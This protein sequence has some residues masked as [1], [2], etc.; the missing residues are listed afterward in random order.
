MYEIVESL[1][2]NNNK[3][4]EIVVNQPQALT[5]LCWDIL[6]VGTGVVSE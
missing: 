6:K 4:Y 5:A 1:F 2:K 3:V